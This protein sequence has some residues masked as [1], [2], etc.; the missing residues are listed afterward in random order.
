MANQIVN[1]APMVIDY[2]TQDLSTRQLPREPDLVP[3][4]LPKFYLFTR[5]GPS[6]PQLVVGNQRNTIFGSET[7]DLRTKYSNHST[8]FANAVNAE[9]NACMI[10]RLIPTDAGPEANVCLFID[11]LPAYIDEYARDS[12][13]YYLRTEEGM[14]RPTGKTIKGY[15]VK[16]TVGN[17]SSVTAINDPMSGFGQRSTSRGNQRCALAD[18]W[19]TP[20]APTD[21]EI[22]STRYPIFEIK[23]SSKGEHGNLSGIRL[24]APTTKTIATMPTKLMQNDLVYP[25]FLQVIRKPDSKSTGKIS[26]TIFNDRR[27]MLTFKKEV[28][29]PTTGSRLNF[30]E[31]FLD[32][33]QNV[34]DV[35]YPIEYGDFG[36]IRVYDD[37]VDRVLSKLLSAEMPHLD[38][39]SDFR[40]GKTM[41]YEDNQKHLYNF[42]SLQDSNAV[43][44]RAAVFVD[45]PDSVR[46]SDQYT[47]YA[48]GGSDGTMDDDIHDQLVYEHVLDYADPKNE[49]QDIAYHVE[50]VMYDTGFTMRTKQAMAS[51][52]A[53]RKDTFI[54]YTTHS[55]NSPVMSGPGVTEEDAAESEFSI[56]RGLRQ[57]IDTYPESD[58]FGTEVMR[59]MIIGRTGRYRNTIYPHRLPLTLEV[60]IKS[61][62]YMGAGNGIWKNG[63]HFDGAPGS[64]LDSMYDF[65]IKW[66]PTSVRNRNWD[67]GLNW[68][69]RYDRKSF[70]FPALKT[71]YDDDTSV[72][73]SYFT[74]IAI[75]QLNKVAH[76]AWREFSGVSHLSNAQLAE[77]V[78]DFVLARV[79]G[80][81]DNR[82]VIKPD[83]FFSDMDVLRGFSWTLPIK[84]YAQN[85]K[86]VMISYVQAY[87]SSDIGQ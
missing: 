48:K 70:F 79:K 77:R 1:A 3:Q 21:T 71:V 13:G 5:K 51:F 63:K 35:R 6:T 38:E 82:F 72:L 59:A 31:T 78:N 29:D 56:A 73:N 36:D 58:Y 30:E 65:N 20:D 7:W 18:S 86:T 8:V 4:H 25:Y 33:Y 83:T 37:N 62:K 64:I 75:C 22:Y 12:K 80:R 52:I 66:V 19:A 74:A 85:M 15:R 27:I 60:A 42:V 47:A 87:R 17:Y 76:A 28:V 9:G 24:W 10:Q 69:Q 40:Y 53:E 68:V 55:Y 23:A 46:L 26:P 16:W 81:F 44:Y 43:P 84:I 67:I 11:I 50:S 14:L 57:F 61:A 39:E 49:L 54:I 34:A 2:G 45:G 41:V 32:H